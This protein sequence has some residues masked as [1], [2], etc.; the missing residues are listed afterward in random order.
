MEKWKNERKERK[1]EKERESQFIINTSTEIMQTMT[2]TRT[3]T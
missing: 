3:V 2:R 1:D